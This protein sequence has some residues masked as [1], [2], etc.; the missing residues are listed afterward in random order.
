MITYD[1][2]KI[3]SVVFLP[4]SSAFILNFYYC[5]CVFMCAYLITGI[6][7]NAHVYWNLYVIVNESDLVKL[8][9]IRC[10]L[11]VKLQPESYLFTNKTFKILNELSV[12]ARF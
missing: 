10:H 1:F 8:I 7:H 5:V 6:Y 4:S 11:G 9:Q 3:L 2:L 12:T